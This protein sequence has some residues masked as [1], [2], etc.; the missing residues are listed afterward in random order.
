MN[1]LKRIGALIYMVLMAA[2]GAL[3]I[4]SAFNVVPTD[5][6]VC[7]LTAVQENIALQSVLGVIG[8]L[9]V[10]IGITTSFRLIKRLE[11]GRII[12][13]QNPDGEVTVSLPAIEDY[14]RKVAK[15]IKEIKDIKSK[16]HSGK[17]GITVI[18]AISMTSNANIPEVTERMQMLLRNS[19]QNML[20][21]EERINIKLHISKILRS[22]GGASQPASEE[23]R[24]SE[25]EIN[26]PF[27]GVD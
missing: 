26:V 24:V 10:V 15:E 4:A 1:F 20:G 19:V 6:L 14:V 12:A 3:F 16:V 13:F 8:G 9:F 25:D 23:E 5:M 2:A 7:A 18:A 11:R 17:K 22:P 21:V 27:Q